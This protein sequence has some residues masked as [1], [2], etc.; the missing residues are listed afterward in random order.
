M[1]AEYWD[2]DWY[3]FDTYE[4]EHPLETL[5]RVLKQALQRKTE[6]ENE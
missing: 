2:K 5:K 6:K 3:E 1:K 4:T